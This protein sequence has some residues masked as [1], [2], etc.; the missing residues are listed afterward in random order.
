MSLFYNVKITVSI[1]GLVV[2]CYNVTATE[3]LLIGYFITIFMCT[4]KAKWCIKI[5]KKFMMIYED[6]KTKRFPHLF[7]ANSFFS[8]ADKLCYYQSLL[9]A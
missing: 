1:L 9:M 2:S 5:K 4:T 3:F 8:T 6:T 7:P